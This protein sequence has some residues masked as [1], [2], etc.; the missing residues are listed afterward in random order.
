MGLFVVIF[1]FFGGGG[2]LDLMAMFF[3]VTTSDLFPKAGC[4]THSNFSNESNRLWKRKYDS[5]GDKENVK[6]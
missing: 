2:D 6:G 1:F 3:F 5:L 4:L